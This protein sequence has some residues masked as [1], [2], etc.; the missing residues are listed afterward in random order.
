LLGDETEETPEA[1]EDRHTQ[2]SLPADGQSDSATDRQRTS[3]KEDS[4]IWVS[5]EMQV[6]RQAFKATN[7]ENAHL[8]SQVR[9]LHDDVDRLTVERR[10]QRKLLESNQQCLHKAETANKRLQMLVNHLKS[11]LDRTTKE[12]EHLRSVEAE[13]NE[14]SSQLQKM[15]S[16]LSTAECQ[17]DRDVATAEAKWHQVL[18]EQRLTETVAKTQVDSDM[19]KLVD[20]VEELEQQLRQ[21]RADHSLTRKGLEHLRVHFS[22]LPTYSEKPSH[23]QKDELIDW[24]Y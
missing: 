19:V 10:E 21:E 2:R 13:R 23:T 24:T 14:L 11:E 8:C 12:L 9:V 17:R 7:E 22:S 6:L 5:N 1:Q 16:E 15:Q 3:V 18:E 20:R 4:C